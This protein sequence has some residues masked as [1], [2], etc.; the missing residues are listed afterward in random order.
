MS[1]GEIWLKHQWNTNVHCAGASGG[2]ITSSDPSEIEKLHR[3]SGGV[4]LHLASASIDS[5]CFSD[6]DFI[7]HHKV[8]FMLVINF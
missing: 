4:S 8:E 3:G 5:N 6:G 1:L 2:A 7:P